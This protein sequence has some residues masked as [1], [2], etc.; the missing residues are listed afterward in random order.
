MKLQN[1]WILSLSHTP[2]VDDLTSMSI[3]RSTSTDIN[4]EQYCRTRWNV[5]LTMR[6]TF[7]PHI[8]TIADTPTQRLKPHTYTIQAVRQRYKFL[9]LAFN[10]RCVPTA[11]LRLSPVQLITSSSAPSRTCPRRAAAERPLLSP[12][13][14]CSPRYLNTIPNLLCSPLPH[15]PGFSRPA[16]SLINRSRA[17]PLRGRFTSTFPPRN[18]PAPSYAE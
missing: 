13:P 18:V 2:V 1:G 6:P 14:L 10:C 15:R 5:F 11:P 8:V 17:A 3:R 16:P 12:P 4:L 9:V 7:P